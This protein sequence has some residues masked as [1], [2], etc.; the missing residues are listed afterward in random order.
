MLLE[1]KG[2]FPD[3]F[4][5]TIAHATSLDQMTSVAQRLDKPGVLVEIIEATRARVA[6]EKL[7]ATA[8]PEVDVLKKKISEAW[9]VSYAKWVSQSTVCRSF[10]QHD[11][12]LQ[13]GMDAGKS[14]DYNE[15]PWLQ[16][17]TE[18]STTVF[19]EYEFIYIN[20][21]TIHS[22]ARGV[23]LAL[24]SADV[25]NLFAN[26]IKEVES[27]CS[28]AALA[29]SKLAAMRR[30]LA[31]IAFGSFLSASSKPPNYAS[32]FNEL[33]TYYVNTMKQSLNDMPSHFAA[34]YKEA[35]GNLGQ[36]KLAEPACHGSAAASASAASSR[37]AESSSATAAEASSGAAKKK[38][39]LSG[40]KTK[41]ENF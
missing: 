36:K 38:L 39:K 18:S 33:K 25:G 4:Q 26:S 8:P 32:M 24:K 20:A 37:T 11:E 16:S 3:S 17:E 35:Q 5:A 41:N 12:F 13:K 34:L 7:L 21:T 9:E 15:A 22:V 31:T 23:A 27:I 40:I 2:L 10:E 30:T 1:K 28:A 19:K 29:S 14:G 6:M